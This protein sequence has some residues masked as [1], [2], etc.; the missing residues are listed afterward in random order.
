MAAGP[1]AL[2]TRSMTPTGVEV[3]KQ[4]GVL[5]VEGEQ[6]VLSDMVRDVL[7]HAP[8]IGVVGAVTDSAQTAEAVER[9]G[10]DAV[11]WVVRHAADAIAPAGLL[12]RHPRLRIVAVEA[13]GAEG[14]LW[15]MRPH[16]KRLD[17]LS[18]DR[19]VE[20]LRREP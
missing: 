18:P 13:D 8:G 10:C 2:E 4:I 3:V 7:Q 1:S 11:V 20:E 16:R 12:N 15:R 9:T 14:W 6:G 17:P 5:F 19:I